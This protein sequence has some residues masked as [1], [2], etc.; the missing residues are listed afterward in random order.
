[1][2]VPGTPHGDTGAW[3]VSDWYRLQLLHCSCESR[4]RVRGQDNAGHGRRD[5]RSLLD[6]PGTPIVSRAAASL[7]TTQAARASFAGMAT[8]DQALVFVTTVQ[9]RAP[10]RTECKTILLN[11]LGRFVYYSR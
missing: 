2:P 8:P 7:G 1:M 9:C 10:G 4:A 6:G 11:S 5:H 3:H